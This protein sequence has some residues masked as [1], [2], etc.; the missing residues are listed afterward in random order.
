MAGG[1]SARNAQRR[2]ELAAFLRA[3]REELRPEDVGIVSHGR[4]R[5]NGLRREEVAMLAAV[6]VSWYTW[7]EQARDIRMSNE[8]LNSVADALKLDADERRYFR[9]LAGS[10]VGDVDAA[11]D[12][13][14]PE[15][16]A[17]LDDLLPDAAHV[18]TG[19]FDLV[20][21]NR[22]S[23]LLFGDPALVP[24]EQRNS[25]WMFFMTDLRHLVG[26]WEASAQGFVARLRNECGTFQDNPRFAA[27]IN[28]LLET[29]DEFRRLWE[30]QEVRS[31]ITPVRTVHHPQSGLIRTQVIQMRPLQHPALILTV[32]RAAD[33]ESRE[34]MVEL[35]ERDH[36]P[37]VGATQD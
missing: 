3:R 23:A 32:H 25:V 26:D 28:E 15:L 22:A 14:A 6:S 5:V 9:R 20:A 34:R 31:V 29:S 10:P 4:R 19:P 2:Q 33:P 18:V 7:L 12:E 11:P 16:L 17:F 13:V 37:R 8:A 27:V 30:R 36:V 1:G 35:L 24:P 21:W